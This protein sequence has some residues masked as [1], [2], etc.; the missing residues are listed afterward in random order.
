M[1]N[2]NSN[3]TLVFFYISNKQINSNNKKS[4]LVNHKSFIESFSR[5]KLISSL[6]KYKI[7]FNIMNLNKHI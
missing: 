6:C 3:I 4:L 7:K 2:N 5:K 1:H